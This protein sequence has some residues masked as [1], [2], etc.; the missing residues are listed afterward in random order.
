VVIQNRAI[1]E[2][3]RSIFNLS[4]QLARAMRLVAQ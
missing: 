1:A 2:M 3:Q 4:F